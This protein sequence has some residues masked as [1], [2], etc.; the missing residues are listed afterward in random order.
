MAAH[1][2]P[3][4]GALSLEI[5]RQLLPQLEPLQKR[6]MTLQNII[7]TYR[8]IEGETDIE[9]LRNGYILA[10]QMRQK[11]SQQNRFKILIL[12][13]DSYMIPMATYF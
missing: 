10:D 9:L 8:R 5:A 1:Q 13:F 12:P 6:A 2:D 3:D 4:L 11:Q 7:R